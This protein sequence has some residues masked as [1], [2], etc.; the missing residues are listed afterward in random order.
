MKTKTLIKDFVI[1]LLSSSLNFFVF[2]L[3]YKEFSFPYLHEEQRVE[4]APYI[5]TYVLPGFILI[6]ILV[7]IAHKLVIKFA[8]KN[9]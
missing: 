8:N 6:S 4:N 2:L 3:A 1:V 7:V 9:S 5:F